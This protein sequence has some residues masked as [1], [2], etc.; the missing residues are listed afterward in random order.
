MDSICRFLYC[1]IPSALTEISADLYQT[2]SESFE[3]LLQYAMA[4]AM[5][6]TNNQEFAEKKREKRFLASN[7]KMNIH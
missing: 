6:D 1:L 5:M 7:S 3:I 4:S 2:L